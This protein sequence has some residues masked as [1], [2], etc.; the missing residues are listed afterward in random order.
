MCKFDV[1]QNLQNLKQQ[2]NTKKYE[3]NSFKF[4]YC[5]FFDYKWLCES[6]GNY[7]NWM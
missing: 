2:L 7:N 4:N 5:S 6:K 3:N 1:S